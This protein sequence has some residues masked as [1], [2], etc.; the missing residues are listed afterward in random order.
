[1]I[2]FASARQ[3]MVDSQ[4]RTTDVNNLGVIGAMLDVPRERF[5]AP[6]ETAL[7][8][9]DRE[10][11]AAR[12]NGRP[13]RYLLR[14]MVLAKLIQAAD[15][16][17]TDRVLDI[18]CGTGYSSAILARL[19]G[20]VIALEDDA[21]LARRARDLLAEIDAPNVT[22]ISGPLEAGW[23]AAAPYDV[24]LINGAVETVP[25]ALLAQLSEGGRLAAIVAEGPVG[26][27]TL[28]RSLHGEVSGAAV[29]NAP[30]PQLP[31][32]AKPAAFVF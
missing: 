24:I 6:G 30:A 13:G 25:Q 10:V 32:F 27:A 7:A 14:P 31:T 18:A 22:V 20:S 8:Y 2:D 23:A 9:L 4:L 29:F 19:A 11:P 5:V 21:E 26:T 28:Y 17:E 15:V 3:K 12:G 1:M 16:R